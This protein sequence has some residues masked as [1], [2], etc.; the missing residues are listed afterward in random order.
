MFASGISCLFCDKRCKRRAKAA[1][2]AGQAGN[3]DF[4]PRDREC[5]LDRSGYDIAICDI[6]LPIRILPLPISAF[7]QVPER[8]RFDRK[9]TWH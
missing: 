8:W 7:W 9:G 2:P 6:R 3:R 1:K 5:E 4:L